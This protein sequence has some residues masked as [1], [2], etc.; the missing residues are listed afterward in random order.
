MEE[1]KRIIELAHEIGYIKEAA[2]G[3]YAVNPKGIVCGTVIAGSPEYNQNSNL[4]KSLRKKLISVGIS[5]DTVSTNTR[6]VYVKAEE[7]RGE[8]CQKNARL[9]N[10]IKVVHGGL[11]KYAIEAQKT[12]IKLSKLMTPEQQ[13]KIAQEKGRKMQTKPKFRK[14]TISKKQAQANQKT[15]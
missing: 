13:E 1:Y 10:M 12:G 8:N 14:P 9:M 11:G 2:Q 7:N 6:Y 5:P 15:T 4:V 3:Y